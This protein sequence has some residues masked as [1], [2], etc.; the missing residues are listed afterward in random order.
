MTRPHARA[1]FALALP[2]ALAALLPLAAAADQHEPEAAD[3]AEAERSEDRSRSERGVS[4]SMLIDLFSIESNDEGSEVHILKLPLFQL[5]E[6]RDRGPDNSKLVI[7]DAPFVSLFRR[8]RGLGYRSLEILDVPLVTFFRS[9]RDED[10]SSLKILGLPLIGS[11]YSSE[12]GPDGS[13]RE[14]LFFIHL[15]SR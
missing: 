2:L 7:V 14:I 11:V 6:L 9:E 5:L 8:V 4:V 13:E 12:T 1:L 3:E 10:S 15:E